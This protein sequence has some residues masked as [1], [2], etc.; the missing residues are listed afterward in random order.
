MQEPIPIF[1]LGTKGRS[2]TGYLCALLRHH[3]DCGPPPAILEREDWLLL[4]TAPLIDFATAVKDRIGNG[5]YEPRDATGLDDDLLLAIGRGIADYLGSASPETSHIVVKTPMLDGLENRKRLFPRAKVVIIVRYG[6][7]SV[8]SSRRTFLENP[9]GEPLSFEQHCRRWSHTTQKIFAVMDQYPGDLMTVR[10]EDLLCDRDRRIRQMCRFLGLDPARY[11]FAAADETAV[12]GSSSYGR[13]NG[14]VTWAPVAKT[15]AF[16][17]LGRSRDWTLEQHQQFNQIC[18]TV[19]T[20]LGY[21]L[22]E[23]AEE[24]SR[25]RQQLK[26]FSL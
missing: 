23:S 17:P 9:R 25:W 14:E 8:E 10:Y 6:P 22:I 11:D 15:D 18:G 4:N 3:P 21:P 7:D 16:Q 24:L 12:Y 2:G 26:D 1:V 13:K 20:R 5:R 19:M